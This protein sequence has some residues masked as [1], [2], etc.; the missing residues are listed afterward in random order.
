MASSLFSVLFT[1]LERFSDASST[2]LLTW[3]KNFDRCFVTANKTDDLV[4][5]QLVMMFV[6]G[7]AKAILEEFEEEKG[8]LQKYS[9]LIEKLKL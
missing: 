7:Q 5:G 3:L 9:T 6:E 1:R 4:K 2:D 8:T